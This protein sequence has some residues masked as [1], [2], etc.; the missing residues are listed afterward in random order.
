M[1]S[2]P[3]AKTIFYDVTTLIHNPSKDGIRRVVFNWLDKLIELNPMES[4]YKVIPIHFNNHSYEIASDFLQECYPGIPT[5]TLSNS[6]IT[7]SKDDILLVPAYDIF[8]PGFPLNLEDF[9][10]TCKVVVVVYDILPISNPEWFPKNTKEIFASALLKSAILADL[11]IVNSQSTKLSLDSFLTTN[12]SVE[13][14][15]QIHKV[16]LSGDFEKFSREIDRLGGNLKYSSQKTSSFELLAVG[17][18]EPRKGYDEILQAFIAAKSSNSNLSLT[19]VGRMGWNCASTIKEIRRVKRLFP[20]HFFWD[21]K[22]DS[23]KLE[24]YY[25]RA[26]VVICASFDEGFGLPLA[27]ALTRGKIALA[28]DTPVFREISQ[29]A[30]VFFGEHGDFKNLTESFLCSQKVI[31]IGMS[32]LQNFRVITP[33]ESVLRLISAIESDQDIREM[34]R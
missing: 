30:A 28:R 15:P 4:G 25:K 17:T 24:Q 5:L 2:M 13:T 27:E 23:F 10:G 6:S 19:I 9:F 8:M 1:K 22:A 29:E 21:S 31:E 3:S 12:L 16:E 14:L 33:S 32:R 34:K 11:I 7:P 18:V 26:D 20:R